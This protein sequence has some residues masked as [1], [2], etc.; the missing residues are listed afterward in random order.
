MI[1]PVFARVL[2]NNPSASE[3]WYEDSESSI[4]SDTVEQRSNRIEPPV[5]CVLD[6][7]DE[8]P[9]TVTTNQEPT[10]VKALKQENVPF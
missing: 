4:Q 6:D 5:I 8:D 10:G 7:D 2:A 3:A 9:A 1:D